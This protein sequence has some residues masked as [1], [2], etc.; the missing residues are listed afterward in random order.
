[1]LLRKSAGHYCT[2]PTPASGS[3]GFKWCSICKFGGDAPGFWLC[4]I[5]VD[6][7]RSW[8]KAWGIDVKTFLNAS[9]KDSAIQLAQ[10]GGSGERTSLPWLR[11]GLL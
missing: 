8:C 3:F 2:W 11:L 1:M 4:L 5:P 10:S 7:E 6:G 9:D